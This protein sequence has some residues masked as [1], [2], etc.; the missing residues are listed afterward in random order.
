[1]SGVVAWRYRTDGIPCGPWNGGA[2]VKYHRQRA[3]D[4]NYTIELAYS[5]A[6]VRELVEALDWAMQRLHEPTES[7]RAAC[8]D[9]SRN[10]DKAC[11]ALAPYRSQT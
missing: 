6:A 3:A 10:W 11:A 2:P 7:V 9:Y 4:Q 5:E 1:M 8:D